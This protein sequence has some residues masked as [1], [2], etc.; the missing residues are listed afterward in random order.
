VGGVSYERGTP[1]VLRGV[2]GR[3][4][5]VDARRGIQGYLAHEKNPTPYDHP[6]SLGI[7]LL[8]GPKGS[9]FLVQ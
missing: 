8:Q 9:R 3:C 4:V 7:C 6:R 1:V 5:R 2:L